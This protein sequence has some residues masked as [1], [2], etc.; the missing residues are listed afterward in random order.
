MNQ[1]NPR[2]QKQDGQASLQKPEKTLAAKF[3][4]FKLEGFRVDR[5]QSTIINETGCAGK[6]VEDRKEQPD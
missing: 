5:Y 6:L 2:H 3:F 4:S 1:K